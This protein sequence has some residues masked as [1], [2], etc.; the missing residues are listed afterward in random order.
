MILYGI[1]D[2]ADPFELYI[3]ARGPSDGHESAIDAILPSRAAAEF[4]RS[5]Y[6]DQVS[7]GNIVN[8][9]YT[10]QVHMQ[11]E[12]KQRGTLMLPDN[13]EKGWVNSAGD[14]TEENPC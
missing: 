12:D 2:N 9:R 14:S 5:I 4:A 13:K 8:R 3:P 6:A 10:S 7:I 11:Y 1:A